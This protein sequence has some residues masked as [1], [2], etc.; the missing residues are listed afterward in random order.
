[1]T[2]NVTT[3]DVQFFEI[4]HPKKRKAL[5]ILIHVPHAGTLIPPEIGLHTFGNDAETVYFD[6]FGL[7]IEVAETDIVP[8]PLQ[9]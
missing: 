6:D 8:A 4:L 1:M 7:L 9:Q 5:P 3:Q 2:S